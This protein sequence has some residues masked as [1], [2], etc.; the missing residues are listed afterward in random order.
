[1]APPKIESFVEKIVATN[2]PD[3]Q[4]NHQTHEDASS[5]GVRIA[6][7]GRSGCR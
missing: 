6:V 7:R 2:I 4:H 3:E 1:M 5:T